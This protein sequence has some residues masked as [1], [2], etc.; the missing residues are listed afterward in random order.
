MKIGSVFFDKQFA[1]HDGQTGE[2][3]F[4]ALGFGDGVY[5]V[6]KTTSKQHGRGTVF[7]CQDDR[8]YNFY[9]PQNSCYFKVCTW[10]CLDEL[11]ELKA[12]E[13]LQKH[14]AGIINPICTLDDVLTRQIQNCAL[15]GL[16][17]TNFQA[18]VMERSLLSTQNPP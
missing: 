6:A 14:F 10:V 8:F 11:Y 7:G 15:N 5:V 4:L 3:L 9:L 1:F 13:V 16:D 12:S 2:K 17:I 18:E